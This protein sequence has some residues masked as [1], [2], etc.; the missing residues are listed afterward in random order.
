[1]EEN[2]KMESGRGRKWLRVLWKTLGTLA[3]GAVLYAVLVMAGVLIAFGTVHW[4]FYLPC[5]LAGSLGLFLVL[6]GAI[7]GWRG[8]RRTGGVVLAGAILVSAG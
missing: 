1:M 8:V 7:W 4:G 2:G 5:L 3:A 6:L